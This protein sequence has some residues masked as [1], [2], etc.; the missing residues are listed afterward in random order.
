VSWYVARDVNVGRGH[1]NFQ[2]WEAQVNPQEALEHLGLACKLIKEGKMPPAEYRVMHKESYVSPAETTAV[3]A[4]T[5]K[6][7][8][9]AD[10]DKKAD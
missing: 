8:A 2:N 5:Q 4:W 10:D 9:V 6:I 1:V 3:C 7:G